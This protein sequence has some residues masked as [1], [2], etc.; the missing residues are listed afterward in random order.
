[1]KTKVAFMLTEGQ[2]DSL[3]RG[4][5]HQYSG[6]DLS[7][8][9]A[10]HNREWVVFR[11]TF[12]CGQDRQAILRSDA[13]QALIG[14]V[15]TPDSREN[16]PYGIELAHYLMNHG[17]DVMLMANQ[18]LFT[19]RHHL[20]ELRA[21][22][23]VIESTDLNFLARG[24]SFFLHTGNR[25]LLGNPYDELIVRQEQAHQIAL[26][27]LQAARQRFEHAKRMAQRRR[28]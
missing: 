8:L 23:P 20:E 16:E 28:R 2:L 10:E 12:Q 6:Q 19:Y 9:C 18:Q 22:I 27:A 14:L 13:D 3:E 21:S 26:G 11:P 5:R 15:K 1:M 25:F 4:I 17:I 24:V 7:Q